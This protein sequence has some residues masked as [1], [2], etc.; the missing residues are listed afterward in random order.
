MHKPSMGGLAEVLMRAMEQS[1]GIV[2]ITDPAGL[3]EY[4]NPMFCRVTGYSPDEIVGKP[5]RILKSDVLPPAVYAGL[6]D[7]LVNGEDWRGEFHNRRKNGEL[8]WE[9][10]TISPIRNEEG[11]TE[12]YL[13]IAE[14]ITRQKAMEAELKE[15]ES[16]RD[17]LIEEMRR[18]SVRDA[19]TGLYS[20]R[21]FDDELNQAW[22]LGERRG[23]PLSL[24][25]LDIDH[26]KVLNDTFG[27][28]V[29][30]QI[31][32]ETS[33]LIRAT[34]RA[35]DIVCRYGGDEIAVILP[36][37]GLDETHRVGERLLD[38]F[39]QNIFCR[40]I[41]DIHVMVSIGAASG[42]G[43]T[44]PA[45][46]ILTRA[47]QALYRAKQLG[48][49]MLCISEPES[50]SPFTSVGNITSR[51]AAVPEATSTAG[52]GRI[53]VV[54]DDQSSCRMIRALLE[55]EHY[56]V[57]VADD[58]DK[59][60]AIVE[61]EPGT[62]DVTL[63]NLQ[64]TK[65]N[66]FDV[67]KQLRL[68]DDIMIGIAMTSHASMDDTT[69]ALRY[70]VVDFIEKP[71]SAVQL[72]PAIERGMQYRRLLQENRHYQ[73]H[74][75]EMVAQR[76]AALSQALS[77]V[78][79]SYKSTAEALEVVLEAHEKKT[80]E[81][82]KRVALMAQILALEMQATAEEVETIGHGSLLHD[83]GKISIP[84]AILSKQGALTEEEWQIMKTHPQTGYN[85]AHVCPCMEKAA[86]I[87]LEHHEHYDGSGYPRGL[88]GVEISLNARIFAVA[89][90]YE[91]IR[92]NRPYASSRS[93]E[94]AISEILKFRGVLFDPDVVDAF[95]RCQPS[96][97]ACISGDAGK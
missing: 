9:A 88:K 45:S 42:A 63:I 94:E 46:H 7:K 43:R 78:K 76:S 67:L 69:A 64:L 32:I 60:R 87:I 66:G 41:H 48:R 91:V 50:T 84:D 37:T 4:V 26:Y 82:C 20:R 81:H 61:S 70:G 73:R 58:A 92:S 3:I 25:M 21:A 40:G 93:A 54:E 6:W 96:L 2:I 30:D 29:G 36:L 77:Q 47:D 8:Y 18:L 14:D 23:L 68:V 51:V 38:A 72:M 62:I 74:L 34:V 89:E 1:P 15:A 52:K 86:V 83:I 16:Q 75:E 35:G 53:L 27:H 44:Q 11:R 17:R 49:N 5:S 28:Q 80:G 39:R 24:L 85:I 31:L 90:A 57:A 59:A 55:N 71:V 12:H 79:Q 56:D 10:A 19:L 22:Q 65:Q 33:H 13:K 97:E 95:L